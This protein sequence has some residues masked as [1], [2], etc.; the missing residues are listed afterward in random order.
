MLADLKTTDAFTCSQF[1]SDCS[2]VQR[3]N[4]CL[5]RVVRQ[6][7]PASVEEQ[8]YQKTDVHLL[9]M[10]LPYINAMAT[11]SSSVLGCKVCSVVIRNDRLA[12]QEAVG[13]WPNEPL[14]NED[15]KHKTPPNSS[16]SSSSG[17]GL[18]HQQHPTFVQLSQ[19]WDLWGARV[20]F[21]HRATTGRAGGTS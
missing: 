2:K 5:R 1:S 16:L 20:C 18:E 19:Q 12:N 3:T 10:A 15:L 9:T 4:Q 7:F 6:T 17:N 8:D 14:Q 21:D 11:P 13:K